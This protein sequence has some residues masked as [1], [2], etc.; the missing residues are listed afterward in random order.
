VQNVPFQ[1]PLWMD[2]AAVVLFSI[3]GAIAAREKRY[4]LGW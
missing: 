4:D 1:L 2:L 3:T